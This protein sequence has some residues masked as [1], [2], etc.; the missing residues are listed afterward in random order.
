MEFLLELRTEELPAS[1]IRA[2]VEQLEAGF[3]KELLGARIEVRA[4]GTLAT[5]RRLVVAGDFADF[6]AAFWEARERT[7]E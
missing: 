6:R 7:S 3:R 4:L 2:A 5:P 1:H